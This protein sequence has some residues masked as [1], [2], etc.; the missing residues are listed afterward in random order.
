MTAWVRVA[1]FM[2]VKTTESAARVV[3][4][5]KHIERITIAVNIRDSYRQQE[6]GHV[7]L[8]LAPRLLSS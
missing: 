2:N 8:L 5:P 4:R 1:R 7:A 6:S 3:T